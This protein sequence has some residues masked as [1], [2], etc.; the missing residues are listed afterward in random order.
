MKFEKLHNGIECN[1]V[2]KA[3][4][5]FDNKYLRKLR[6]DQLSEK[7]FLTHWERGIGNEETDCEKICSYNGISINQADEKTENIIIEKYKTTF[8]INPKK[9]AHLLKFKIKNNAGKVSH[10]PLEDDDTH[11]NF[12]KSD[13]FNLETLEVIETVKF[14]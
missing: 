8:N 11:Y 14:V 12:F 6:K 1:C 9:G 10:A 7:D 5:D 3:V 2:K 4:D 13:E